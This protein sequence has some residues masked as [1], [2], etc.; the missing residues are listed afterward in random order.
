M[1]EVNR[2]TKPSIRQDAKM[3]RP[4]VFTRNLRLV[5]CLLSVLVLN[6][7]SRVEGYAVGPRPLHQ[8]DRHVRVAKHLSAHS[9]QLRPTRLDANVASPHTA[10]SEPFGHGLNLCAEEAPSHRLF[11]Q[12]QLVRN[13]RLN[14]KNAFNARYNEGGFS[15]A[16]VPGGKRSP[17]NSS[18]LHLLRINQENCLTLLRT[19]TP[20]IDATNIVLSG[21]IQYI[22]PTHAKLLATT[23]IPSKKKSLLATTLAQ[24]TSATALVRFIETFTS[25][26]TRHPLTRE[27]HAASRWILEKCLALS[28]LIPAD[29][30]V[31]YTVTKVMHDG[32]DQV[33]VIARIEAS[34][35]VLSHENKHTRR[36]VIV[37]TNLD[38]LNLNNPLH[39]RAPGATS[40]GA[41]TATLH[42]SLR[43]LLSSTFT[44]NHGTALEFHFY[45][46]SA[47]GLQGSMQVAA[48]Y[49]ARGVPV[50]AMLGVQ[51]AG[52]D[53]SGFEAGMTRRV[54]VATDADTAV[55]KVVGRM[56]KGSGLDV[57][58]RVCG[59]ACADYASWRLHGY[60]ASQLFEADDETSASPH[61]HRVTDDLDTVSVARMHLF[62]QI[63][64]K[65]A[66]EMGMQ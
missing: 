1:G 3:S 10:V 32:L 17:Q 43:V 35:D 48:H 51:N 2:R 15:L 52:W 11:S 46:A 58:E 18:C 5:H 33:T 39:A 57:V 7:C 54:A 16:L 60:P 34:Q 59:F 44:P 8:L 20:F 26:H 21:L 64:V 25:F 50:A 45:A 38:A 28:D 22:P 56:V 37:G 53:P 63:V 30:S 55:S 49:A 36:V 42:E 61:V 6:L 40:S 13:H 66:V 4:P 41:N 31:N 24:N 62:A 47:L 12:N 9:L 29:S 19:Q 23:I 27:G 14:E 65:F